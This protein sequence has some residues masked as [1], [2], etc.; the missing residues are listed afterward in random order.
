MVDGMTRE[1]AA[2]R[3]VEGLLD[4]EMIRMPA[5]GMVA[6][7]CRIVSFSGWS[8]PAGIGD[9]RIGPD[10]LARRIRR[11][12]PLPCLAGIELPAGEIRSNVTLSTCFEN[13]N[14]EN[15]RYA[16]L[17]NGWKALLGHAVD[18]RDGVFVVIVCQLPYS[19]R[20]QLD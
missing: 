6:S 18:D 9:F 19:W 7:I 5:S 4:L 17:F 1:R 8:K 20:L 12:S 10:R 11:S 14:F 2:A 3:G 15:V 13:V 16:S